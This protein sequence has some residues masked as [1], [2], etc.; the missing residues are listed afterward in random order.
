MGGSIPKQYLEIAEKTI[1]EHTLERLCA[2]P[3]I[4]K[5]LV[6]IAADD[7]RWQSLN[8]AHPKLHG[9]VTGGLQ[10]G[11]SVLNMLQEVITIDSSAWALVHDAVRPCVS[12]NDIENLVATARERGYGGVLGTP[13]NDTV[14]QVKDGNVIEKTVPR[15]ALW[16]A[17][18]PQ[19]FSVES[20]FNALNFCTDVT[21]EAGAI[22]KSGE[23]VFLLEGAAD[24]IKITH[25][26]DLALAELILSSQKV[27]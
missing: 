27:Q 25:P 19:L 22:E 21:D 10:R 8:F 7:G 5:L 20:L 4:D 6:A 11:D 18:T 24:N 17:F 23:Q 2:C 15:E 9:V 14:K 13:I 26:S 12:E 1:L 16:R 3:S